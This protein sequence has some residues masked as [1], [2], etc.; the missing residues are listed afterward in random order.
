MKYMCKRWLTALLAVI[1]MAAFLAPLAYMEK[2]ESWLVEE[3]TDEIICEETPENTADEKTEDIPAQEKAAP[4][5]DAAEETQPEHDEEAEASGLSVD[6][7]EEAELTD[8]EMTPES[9]ADDGILLAEDTLSE[10]NDTYA[11]AVYP[12]MAE[13]IDILGHVYVMTVRPVQLYGTPERLSADVVYN[14]AQ[15]N[16]MLLA[17]DYVQFDHTDSVK[18]WLVSENGELI[19][20]YVPASML[21]RDVRLDNDLPDLISY[22]PVVLTYTDAGLL[23]VFIV[24]GEKPDD[25]MHEE[26]LPRAEEEESSI[27]SGAEDDWTTDE[28]F[29]EQDR[30]EEAAACSDPEP[31][32]A[33][34][35]RLVSTATRVF[36][37][38]DDTA[39]EDTAGDLYLGYF[40]RD[41]VVQI[42][43]TAKDTQDRAWYR[44]RYLYG[45][46]FADGTLKWTATDS[47]W[48]LAEETWE[49]ELDALTVTDYAFPSKPAAKRR[50]AASDMNGFSLKEINGPI[51]AFYAG[52]TNVYGSS[53]HD[54]EYKQIASLAGHGA[55]YA[56]PHY[57]DGFT[58]Y[59]LEHTLSGPGEGSGSSQKPKGP[60]MIVDID[61]YMNTPGNSKVIY[62]EGT[63]HAIAWVLRHTYPF[64]VLDR[65]DGDNE[66]WSRVSG[67]FAIREVIKQLEGAQ[68]VRDYWDMDNFYAASGQAPEVYLTYARWLAANGIARASITGEI[69]AADQSIIE[70]NGIY[71]GSVTLSMILIY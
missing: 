68:Y 71:T 42:E 37:S 14:V 29:L 3:T 21:L 13:M 64:M 44:A 41:A 39:S 56:T 34:D 40:V 15:E 12:E 38:I 7:A 22:L 20:G 54:W 19:E 66:S 26:A 24:A 49:T 52:Q 11:F 58:V 51:G 31:P 43:E 60:Y 23:H 10:E 55:I 25:G 2:E 27:E 61:S 65:S 35:Y 48:L 6:E 30:K 9:S 53:G 17:T 50:M 5:L 67:Q 62:H 4:S 45:D 57:L 33:G 46:D 69:I 8:D 36:L 47:V 16:A 1:M 63:M 59:C 28:A 18:V 70:Q 32:Q